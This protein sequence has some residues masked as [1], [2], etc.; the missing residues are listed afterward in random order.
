M[1]WPLCRA[2]SS[3]KRSATTRSCANHRRGGPDH[4]VELADEPDRRQGRPGAGGG[5]HDC[6][7]AQRGSPTCAAVFAEV[8]AAAGVPGRV[9]SGAGRR[10]GRGR[11][12]RGP[13]RHRHGQL[14]RID[15]RRDHGGQGR[16]RH[17]QARDAG[18]GRQIAQHHPARHA[19][20]Q[21]AARRLR[22]RAP[23][24][25]ASCVAPTR[26]LVHVSQHDEAAKLAGEI[27]AARKSAI[28]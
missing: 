25:G 2:M 20:G 19:A 7:E 9:Q 10:A 16:R 23:Q 4:P 3:R 5:L 26:M 27:L 12:H 17:G 14:Y 6:V 8:L 18:T 22:R 28:R 21:G 15:P 24:F 13:P 1:R 11:G